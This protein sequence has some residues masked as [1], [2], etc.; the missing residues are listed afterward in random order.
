MSTWRE[1]LFSDWT[2][3]VDDAR[4]KIHK[5]LFACGPRSSEFLKTSFLQ[6]G[7]ASTHVTV[8]DHLPTEVKQKAV[9]ETMLDHVYEGKAL[10][11]P[12]IAIPLVFIGEVPL[13]FFLACPSPA[14][15]SL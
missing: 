10:I 11:P 1:G 12:G 6:K 7:F 3:Q 2:L 15:V 4:Y 8:L 13:F 9:M 5:F 14:S